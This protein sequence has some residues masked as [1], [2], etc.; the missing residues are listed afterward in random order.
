METLTEGIILSEDRLLGSLHY[1]GRQGGTI[2][3]V[4]ADIKTVCVYPPIPIRSF[5]WSAYFDSRYDGEGG[6]IGSGP[7]K[8]AAINDL[9]EQM[10]EYA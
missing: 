5:D 10:E 7:T 9:L 8:E 6:K 4:L 1:L 3:Q 2:H